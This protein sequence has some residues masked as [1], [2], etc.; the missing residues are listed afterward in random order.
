MMGAVFKTV[1]EL[2]RASLGGFDSHTPPPEKGVGRKP[3][4]VKP[5]RLS[6]IYFFVYSSLLTIH[7]SL[8]EGLDL[9]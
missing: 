2:V 7:R 3:S 8:Y 4:A 5:E 1:S 9:P 6:L